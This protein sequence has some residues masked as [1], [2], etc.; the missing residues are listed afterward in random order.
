MRIHCKE[1]HTRT[2]AA[3]GRGVAPRLSFSWGDMGGIPNDYL[4]L[5]DKNQMFTDDYQ[6]FTDDYLMM[7]AGRP[8]RTTNPTTQQAAA[9]TTPAARTA[10]PY[11]P[12]A[13]CHV[14]SSGLARL[15]ASCR[16]QQSLAHSTGSVSR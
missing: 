12:P 1:A 9:P 15:E 4:K 14:A 3:R 11:H 2:R 6:M 8:G 7:A 10:L 16:S 13:P 5:Q